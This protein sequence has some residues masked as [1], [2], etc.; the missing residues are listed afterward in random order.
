VNAQELLVHN[1]CERESTER[2]HTR[3][4]DPLRVLVLACPHI[5]SSQSSRDEREMRRTLELEGEVV[6]QMAALVVTAQQ[7]EGIG[8]VDLETPEVQN[9]LGTNPRQLELLSTT[10]GWDSL[11][12]RSNHDRRSLPG[13]GT[14][15][16]RGYLQPRTASS[17]RTVSQRDVV[18][19]QSDPR[20]EREYARIVHGCHHT[21]EHTR[22]SAR[23]VGT[24]RE[25]TH[26]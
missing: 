12:W 10:T 1:C 16:Q 2:L 3:V 15:Y 4:I 23:L 26:P 19:S 14:A 7:E 22:T 11:R 5:V 25:R 8:V 9:T 17:S 24:E 18:S 6:G 21:L 20:D 13:R